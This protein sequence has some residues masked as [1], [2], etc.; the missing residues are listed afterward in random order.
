MALHI[1]PVC[2]YAVC[3]M[4]T[5]D[6][7]ATHATG[8]TPLLTL[9]SGLV[10]DVSGTIMGRRPG[11]EDFSPEF[12]IALPYRGV[13]TWH[14]GGNDVIADANQ[15][16]FVTGGEAFRV[17]GPPGSRYAELILTPSFST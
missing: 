14:V 13:F 5:R 12:Q 16:L 4:Q 10:E 15:I 3:E 7:A 11:A 1:R 6:E 2:S 9:P 8:R 17:S